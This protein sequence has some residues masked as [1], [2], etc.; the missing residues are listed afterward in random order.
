MHPETQGFPAFQNVDI[1]SLALFFLSSSLVT[2][3]TATIALQI[4]KRFPEIDFG[5]SAASSR[6]RGTG[7]GHSRP[8]VVMLF[9]VM[10][11]LNAFQWGNVVLG[12]FV[13]I[14][15]GTWIAGLGVL[16]FVLYIAAAFL[17]SLSITSIVCRLCRKFIP[18]ESEAAFDSGESWTD[19]REMVLRT[20][21]TLSV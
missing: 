7:P 11:L 15:A 17:Y 19:P 21:E 20:Q 16:G 2:L 18:S 8:L 12:T 14:L 3:L 9:D 5:V 13:Y 6:S 4:L 1:T 10:A